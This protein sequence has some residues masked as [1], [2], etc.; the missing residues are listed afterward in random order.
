MSDEEG[1]KE[2]RHQDPDL[3]EDF[4]QTEWLFS[5]KGALDDIPVPAGDACVKISNILSNTSEHSGDFS[6]GGQAEQMPPVPGLF[7]DEV[8]PIPI[9][10]W[11]ER[12]RS[13]IDKAEKSPFGHNMDTKL[14]ENVRKSWQISADHVQFKN[15]Q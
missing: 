5:D 9:P 15:P 1:E 2:L 3:Q 8:G 13:L 10:L 6:F 4:G 7:V 11:D 14:D 12:A